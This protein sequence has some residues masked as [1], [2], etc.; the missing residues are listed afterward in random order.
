MTLGILFHYYY[1]S[2]YFVANIERDYTSKKRHLKYKE[3]E[4]REIV[5][6]VGCLPCL[7]EILVWFLVSH[8]APGAL[9][10]VISKCRARS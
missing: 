7:G 6:W 5:Q 3:F 4:V 10:E 9:R 1:L 2:S 8:M